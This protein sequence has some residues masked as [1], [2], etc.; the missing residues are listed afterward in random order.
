MLL[1][2]RLFFGLLARIACPRQNLLLENLALHHQLSALQRRNPQP[3]LRT[4]DRLFWVL[5]RWLWSGWRDALVLVQPDTVVRWHRAG[6]KC[7]WTWISQ[8]RKRVGRKCVGKALR[9]LIFR[10]VAE[11]STWALPSRKCSG[12]L[13]H[14]CPLSVSPFQLATLRLAVIPT[15][16]PST[17]IEVWATCSRA[18][19]WH[20]SV[21]Y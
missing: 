19:I 12:M 16:F 10:M 11:N 5:L 8:R 2:L 13:D 9:D 1:L 3:R 4:A 20:G 21:R 17:G 15:R 7:H 6:F 14:R 18:D